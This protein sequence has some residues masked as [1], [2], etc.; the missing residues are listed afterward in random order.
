MHVEAW[1]VITTLRSGGCIDNAGVANSLTSKLAA[2]QAYVDAG[3]VTDALTTLDAL[4]NALRAQ[5]GKHI[6]TSCTAGS[7]SFNPNATLI[8]DVQALIGA[9]R[10]R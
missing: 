2:A 1:G 10:E 7:V 9:L 3:D 5:S 6:S 4:L 8:T